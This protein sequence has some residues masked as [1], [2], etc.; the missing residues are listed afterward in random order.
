VTADDVVH[1][2]EQIPVL[3]SRLTGGGLKVSLSIMVA[4]RES[5]MRIVKRRI[6]DLRTGR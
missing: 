6:P 1:A 3:R 5:A 4:A 2:L